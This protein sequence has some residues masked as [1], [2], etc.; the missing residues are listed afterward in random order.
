MLVA[1]WCRSIGVGPVAGWWRAVGA[2]PVCKGV[3]MRH[4][5]RD[6]RLGGPEWSIRC[7]GPGTRPLLGYGPVGYV[8]IV[9]GPRLGRLSSG[10]RTGLGR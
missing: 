1:G 10:P 8:S 5:T 2:G 4:W 3:G 9:V 7:G 6:S